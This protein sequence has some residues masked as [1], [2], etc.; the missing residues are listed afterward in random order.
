MNV[1]GR[2]P[3][4]ITGQRFGMLVV[5]HLLP[6]E[7]GRQAHWLCQCDCGKQTESTGT[8]L[9]TG[10]VKSCGCLKHVSR[11]LKEMEGQRFGKLVVLGLVE[12][13]PGEYTAKSLR[14][15]RCQCDCGKIVEIAGPRLRSGITN[16]CGCLRGLKQR[17]ELRGE[18]FGRLVVLDKAPTLEGRKGL[19]WHCICDCGRETNV[20]GASLRRGNTKSCGCLKYDCN[21]KPG[22]KELAGKKF[23]HL[24]VLGRVSEELKDLDNWRVKCDC[25]T[26][27]TLPGSRLRVG[28]VRSCGCSFHR[29][30]AHDLKD[31]TFGFLTAKEQVGVDQSGNALWRC[32]CDCGN[33]KVVSASDLKGGNHNSCGCRIRR[34]RPRLERVKFRQGY[35]RVQRPGH[36]NADMRG[37]VLE[38]VYVMSQH[39]GRAIGHGETVHHKNGIRDDNRIEN[40]ELWAGDHGSGTRVDDE[41]A[42]AKEILAKYD[43]A[44]LAVV[45]TD[46]PE[47]ESV[48][49]IH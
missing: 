30:H 14:K 13:A 27:K 18:R 11:K 43:P 23:G 9:R 41:V 4:D 5:L 38:H 10:A 21:I 47:P 29:A 35:V 26:I 15:W 40:L 37:Y 2:V 46:D 6:K 25:G 31:K 33:E 28:N 34:K 44:A 16:S 39:I 12:L 1:N 22:M 42:H 48:P 3:I 49:T 20:S 36:P 7:L 32:L 8:L 17:I 24:E 19:I 45:P